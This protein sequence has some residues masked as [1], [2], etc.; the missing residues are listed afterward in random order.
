MDIKFYVVG[1]L[2]NVEDKMQK[3]YSYLLA[4]PMGKNFSP[5]FKP[6]LTP[7]EMLRLGVFEG[8]YLNDCRK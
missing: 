1:N 5:D 6:E 3:G 2:V 8:K 7:Q 4:E